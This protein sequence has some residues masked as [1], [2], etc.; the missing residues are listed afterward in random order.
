MSRPI[1]APQGYWGTVFAQDVIDTV[2]AVGPGT[3]EANAL[4]ERYREQTLQSG[5]GRFPGSARS[6]GHALSRLGMVREN[7]WHLKEIQD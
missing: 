2:K 1:A 5:S 3:Y 4:Y 6:F 7:V